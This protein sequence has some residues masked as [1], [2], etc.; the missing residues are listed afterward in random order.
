[1]VG[2]DGSLSGGNY[3][4]SHTKSDTVY[5]QIQVLNQPVENRHVWLSY[6][7]E[8]DSDD[9]KEF[10]AIF[11]WNS[12]DDYAYVEV[13][14]TTISLKQV[15]A[16]G[17]AQ[18]LDS[19][20]RISSKQFWYDVT[21]IADGT[22]VQVWWAKR[23]DPTELLIQSTGVTEQLSTRFFM[24]VRP[25]GHYRFDDVMWRAPANLHEFLKLK[26]LTAPNPISGNSP[27]L[28]R[29]DLNDHT[30]FNDFDDHMGPINAPDPLLR[31][32][33]PSEE[34]RDMGALEW[35]AATDAVYWWENF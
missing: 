12:W 28:D 31:G 16:G 34:V 35:R 4:L 23:G 22:S 19:V 1:M 10:R 18:T 25:Y 32:E 5:N 2:Q 6:Y 26:G 14:D 3:Y 24:W 27:C 15:V 11:R 30:F 33:N 7:R 8:L 17:A 21:I 13:S 29:T 20:T 9:G